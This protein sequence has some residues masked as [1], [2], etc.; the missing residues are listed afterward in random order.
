MRRRSHARLL[1]NRYFFAAFGSPLAGALFTGVAFGGVH[2]ALRLIAGQ[3]RPW[4]AG[5]EQ[6]LPPS[7]PNSSLPWHIVHESSSE[8]RCSCIQLGAL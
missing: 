5:F 4:H 7:R 1:S 6:K 3:L 2:S 8:S